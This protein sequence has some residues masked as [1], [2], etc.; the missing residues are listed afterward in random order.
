MN[1][2]RSVAARLLQRCRQ[3]RYFA[4]EVLDRW[5]TEDTT[6]SGVDRR[7]LTQ[8]VCGVIRRRA[9]LDAVIQPLVDRP[10]MAVEP[11]LRDLLRL[12]AYQLV[13]LTH[14]P[15]YAAVD[16]TV[17]SAEAVGGSRAKG[18]L[19]AV[20]RRLA[21][22]VSDEFTTSPAAD[23]VP[24]DDPLPWEAWA[25][26]VPP[27]RY[28]R[29]R[30]AVLPDPQQHAL[31]YLAVAFSLPRSLLS[32]W[33]ERHGWQETL[34]WAA[35]FNAPPPLWLRVHTRK[36]S[37]EMFRDRLAAA[38]IAAQCGPHPQSLYLPDPPPIR[39]IPGYAEGEFTVQDLSAM[40]VAPA[41]EPHP[42]MRILDLCAAPG[43][44][45]THLA[46]LMND[47]GHIL[48]CDIDPR[49]LETLRSLVQRLGL[50]CIEPYLLT[51]DASLPAASFDAVLVDAPCSNTGVL[52][53]RVEARWRWRTQDLK[54]LTR[55]QTDLLLQALQCVR[56]GGV[57]VYSTCSLEPE[58]N[59]ELI[60]ALRRSYPA[61]Q[62]EHQYH[63]LPGRPADGG[64][65]VRLRRR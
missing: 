18:F 54:T 42:G 31:D 16:E 20:L 51:A 3:G 9:T 17:A 50:S 39:Q 2:V 55:R 14:I 38:G 22:L 5:L 35:F 7:L 59:E 12:G 36:I 52:H 53:R 65:H 47:Q 13:V 26:E 57:V 19:N 33:L 58:E 30:Q 4:S 10:W 41:L 23:A 63:A 45:T 29:L 34:R 44:K 27:L 46:E 56:P 43:G 25:A 48:A 61:L 21:A 37:R 6:L 40:L 15:A 62:I 64:Y 8:L 49:R 32:R 1:A 11:V 24:V 28:R 60:Q